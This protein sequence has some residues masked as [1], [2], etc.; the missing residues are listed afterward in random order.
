MLLISEHQR[1]FVFT[2]AADMRKGFDTLAGLVRSQMHQN[3]LSGDMF[4]FFNRSRT[5]VKILLWER[6]GFALYFKRLEK[7]T[8]EVPQATAQNSTRI[9][10]QT[11]SLILQGI[12]LSSVQRKKRYEHAA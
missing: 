4:I 9:T 12:V 11:L 6:D 8:F 3:P 10:A 1:Y 7:G 2:G 5:H